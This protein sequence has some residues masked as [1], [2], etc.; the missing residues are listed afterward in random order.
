[1][2]R[3]LSGHD[4]VARTEKTQRNWLNQL[5]QTAECTGSTDKR[6]CRWE[7]AGRMWEH[8]SAPLPVHDFPAK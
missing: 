2:S 7:K 8:I 5:V 6:P 3:E 1:M 4:R